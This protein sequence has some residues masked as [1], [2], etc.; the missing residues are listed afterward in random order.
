VGGINYTNQLLYT[1][2]RFE[3]KDGRKGKGQGEGQ[4]EGIG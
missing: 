4:K 1:T 3:R 2:E